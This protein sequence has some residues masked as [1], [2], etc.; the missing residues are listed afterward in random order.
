MLAQ[1][2]HYTQNYNFISQENPAHIGNF[3]YDHLDRKYRSLFLYRNQWRSIKS[4]YVGRNTPF[5]TYRMSID[6]VFHVPALLKA[7]YLG[8]GLN[9][10]RESAGDLNLTNQKVE[11]PVSIN[12]KM[13]ERRFSYLSF[14]V[15][16]SFTQK[17]IELQSAYY[18]NQW[19]GKN[20]DPSLPTGERSIA[21]KFSFFDLSAGIMYR[22]LNLFE[23]LNYGVG[24]AVNNLT[25]PRANFV[26]TGNPLKRRF[27]LHTSGRYLLK[28]SR[29]LY[30]YS[31]FWMQ[32]ELK[33][34]NLVTYKTVGSVDYNN[35]F[36][37]LGLGLRLVGGLSTVSN[38]AL[39]LH[40]IQDYK[41]FRFSLSYDLNFSSLR[42]ASGVKGGL[43]IGILF[44]ALRNK[45]HK[46]VPQ[47]YR[48][49]KTDCPPH[50][51]PKDL[52][53]D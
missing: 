44:Y 11:V 43:E 1:D 39:S 14:G 16:P 33:E 23:K 6:G 22:N 29:N 47:G 38:D 42:K 3:D 2:Y 15:S 50:M 36:S 31:H 45:S 24:F 37:Y 32:G 19:N 9:V 8:V 49:G 17:S 28:P 52:D 7:N 18:D 26:E 34:F 27:A 20:F 5:E 25:E 4:P 48:Y 12:I 30:Y 10:L 40:F 46:K 51:K 53:F 13:D 41:D 35:T 21:D